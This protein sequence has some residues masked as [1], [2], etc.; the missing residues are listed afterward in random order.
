M[1]P[2]AAEVPAEVRDTAD[3]GKRTVFRAFRAEL[4]V[5]TRRYA[6]EQTETLKKKTKMDQTDMICFLKTLK[7]CTEIK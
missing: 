6:D 1:L 3:T 2:G 4:R 7:T 5:C